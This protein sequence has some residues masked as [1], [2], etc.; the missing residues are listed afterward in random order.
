MQFKFRKKETKSVITSSSSNIGFAD[1][2]FGN[3]T[4]RTYLSQ[5]TQGYALSPFVFRCACLRA[6]SVASV[7]PRLL[8]VDDNEISDQNHPL[9]KLLRR[10]SKGRSWHDLAYD[11][12]HDMAINGNAYVQ[13]IR[14]LSKP[15][16]LW[17]LNP[18]NVQPMQS[19]DN[20][21]PVKY[22]IY[23]A[24][25][26]ILNIQP[27]DLIHIH[28][29][30]KPGEVVGMSPLEAASASIRAQTSSRDWNNSLMD[31]AGRPSCAVSVPETMNEDVFQKF[32]NRLSSGYGGKENAGKMMVLDGGKTI[33]NLG[34]NALEMDFNSGM[35]LM[36]REIS[37]AMAVPPELVG[38]SA[39]KTY[40]NA[41]E[42]NK[43]FTQHTVVPELDTLFNALTI[44]L[45]PY[46]T[47]VARISY[48]KSD[49]AELRGNMPEIVAALNSV[50]FMT[51]NEKRAQ[52]GYDSIGEEGDT[53]LVPA[54]NI[55]LSEAAT[56]V[57]D[58]NDPGDNE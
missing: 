47:D 51:T 38:D 26:R 6:A 40:A 9:Y 11:M 28:L 55:P 10:P 52:M 33:T 4:M 20:Y 53:I 15:I 14:G 57:N 19:N 23:N 2:F 42:A 34:F 44:N 54:G 31:H 32:K 25:N 37:I 49:V 46:W 36:A 58:I 17:N 41:Q 27:E 35:V 8:D 48:D 22:W 45:C 1:A 39:N 7:Q 30:P 18:N 16:E 24:G 29:K 56:P 12:E 13:S 50:N 43:E 5:F 3:D 21:E